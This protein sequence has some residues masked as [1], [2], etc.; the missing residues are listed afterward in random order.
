[1][2]LAVRTVESLARL[3][4]VV[5]VIRRLPAVPMET[6]PVASEVV[7]VGLWILHT[8]AVFAN[9]KI[10]SHNLVRADFVTAPVRAYAIL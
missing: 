8:R 5:T 9:N 3:L 7:V 10:G 2:P 1:M 6:L 4:V